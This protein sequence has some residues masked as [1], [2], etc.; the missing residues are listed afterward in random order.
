M[1]IRWSGIED[2]KDDLCT[3]RRYGYWDVV[4]GVDGWVVYTDRRERID[5][6][7]SRDEAR[8]HAERLIRESES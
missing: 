2:S 5:G 7:T 1:V 3:R 8:L 6:F 4:H